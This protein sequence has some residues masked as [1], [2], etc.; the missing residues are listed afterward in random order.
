LQLTGDIT[1]NGHPLATF[2]PVRTAAYIDQIDNHLP[3]LTVRETLE[4]SRRFIG[5]GKRAGAAA[6]PLP[7]GAPA[8]PARFF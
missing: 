6:V 7:F 8:K 5:S 2:N 4:Y 1:Y 3:L